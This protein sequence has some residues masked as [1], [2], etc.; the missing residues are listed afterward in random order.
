MSTGKRDITNIL[1]SNKIKLDRFEFLGDYKVINF[2]TVHFDFESNNWN[3][4]WKRFKIEHFFLS[5]DCD[6]EP[7]P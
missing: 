6:R 2:I 7:H 1:V 4:N 3:L 5:P